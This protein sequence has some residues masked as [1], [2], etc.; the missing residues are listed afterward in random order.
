MKPPILAVNMKAYEGAFGSK[1]RELARAASRV[2][3]SVGVTVILVAPAI[4]AALL[5]SIHERVYIQ[6]SD[7]KGFGSHTGYTPTAAV[8]LE[9]VRGVMVNHSEHK[10]VYRDVAAVVRE[11]KSVGLETLVCADMPGEAAGLAF[12]EPDMIAVEPP[13]LIGTGVPVSRARP[14]VITESVEAVKRVAPGVLVL[15]GAGITGG[16]DAKRSL[17]LGAAG[18]LVASAIMKARDPESK[19]YEMAEAMASAL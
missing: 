10:M 5:S 16:S 15:A 4:N 14:E 18:V 13:E 19:M 1:A 3:G 17:E 7:P 2:E 8:K 9:G 11:A 6:H 12:L